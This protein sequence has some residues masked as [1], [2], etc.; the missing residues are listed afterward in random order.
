MAVGVNSILEVTIKTSFAN[1]R[2]MN[3]LHWVTTVAPTVN[4]EI[5]SQDQLLTILTTGGAKDVVTPMRNTMSSEISIDGL[6][7]QYIFPVRIRR[8]EI[9]PAVVGA[10]AGNC[11]TGNIA[12]VIGKGSDLAGK[13]NT[14]SIHVPGIPTDDY[15]GGNISVLRQGTL[16]TFADACRAELVEPAGGLGRWSAIIYHRTGAPGS[17]ALWTARRV[18]PTL[19]TMRRRTVGV[20]I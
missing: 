20:G 9:N 1:Q 11:K 19:R 17:Y 6:T 2:F 12:G 10:L 4:G 15:T 14:G 16:A 3:V 8:S 18:F 5:A 7:T 13:A